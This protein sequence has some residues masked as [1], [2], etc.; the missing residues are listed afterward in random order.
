M[1]CLPAGAA[2]FHLRGPREP[3]GPQQVIH[4]PPPRL[5]GREQRLLE[6]LGPQ[7]VAVYLR[8]AR[9]HRS[10]PSGERLSRGMRNP[11]LQI[12]SGELA[13]SPP[14]TLAGQC[15]LH[16]GRP[17]RPGVGALLLCRAS[18][19]LPQTIVFSLRQNRIKYHREA[20]RGGAGGP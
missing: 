10:P 7:G 18:S 3:G 12:Y 17:T 1:G 15:W 14:L 16:A 2:I 5:T 9:L 19:T 11:R 13:S 20:F 4:D 6:T 8:D